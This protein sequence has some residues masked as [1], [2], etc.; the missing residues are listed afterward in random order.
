MTDIRHQE[1]DSYFYRE[2]EMFSRDIELWDT[3][4]SSIL[5]CAGKPHGSKF[6]REPRNRWG[7]YCMPTNVITNSV[8]INTASDK[9]KLTHSRGLVCAAQPRNFWPQN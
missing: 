9:A 7:I 2:W 8:M 1:I 6:S 4:L 3:S 5:E